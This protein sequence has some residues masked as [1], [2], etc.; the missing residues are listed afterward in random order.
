MTEDCLIGHGL[1][2]SIVAQVNGGLQANSEA[3]LQSSAGG[4]CVEPIFELPIKEGAR[5]G[6]GAVKNLSLPKLPPP[7]FIYIHG[8]WAGVG[9]FLFNCTL[10]LRT[11]ILRRSL[12]CALGHLQILRG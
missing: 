4:P 8:L 7:A 5:L 12:C 10:D 9:S 6:L 11:E 2:A 1:S 3:E